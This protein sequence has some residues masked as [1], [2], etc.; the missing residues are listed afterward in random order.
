MCVVDR[1]AIVFA[2]DAALMRPLASKL[3]AHA[4]V[5]TDALA[6]LHGA[7]VNL[8]LERG[9]GSTVSTT[10]SGHWRWVYC[11]C[12]CTRCCTVASATTCAL[13]TV[14]TATAT[15]TSCSFAL[16]IAAQD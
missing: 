12:C 14:P 2:A 8:V 9:L 4:L 3:L 1:R 5:E 15:T 16:G 6:C 11:A 13:T 7:L 10:T